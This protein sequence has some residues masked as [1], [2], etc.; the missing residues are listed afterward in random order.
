MRKIIK[1]VIVI[2]LLFTALTS[3]KNKKS[4]QAN[5]DALI[6]ISTDAD[7]NIIF[8]KNTENT[9]TSWDLG[10]LSI[11]LNISDD[12]D[13]LFE[14][15][16][17]FDSDNKDELIIAFGYDNDNDNDKDYVEDIYY[18]GKDEN[19]FIVYSHLESSCYNYY[20]V[21]LIYLE[22]KEQPVLYFR[23]TNYVNLVGFELYEIKDKA[24]NQM[25]YSASATGVGYDEMLDL[26]EDGVYTGYLQTRKSYDSLYTNL[27]RHYSYINGEFI[28]EDISADFY[29]YPST[30]EDVVREYLNMHCLLRLEN[31]DIP[32]IESRLKEL[33]PRNFNPPILYDYNEMVEYNMLYEGSIEFKTNTYEDSNIAKVIVNYSNNQ[34][35]MEV[36]YSL[37]ECESKWI[38]CDYKVLLGDNYELTKK[39]DKYFEEI[40]EEVDNDS[41]LEKYKNILLSQTSLAFKFVVAD[42][43]KSYYLNDIAFEGYWMKPF[44][45]S[46][47]DMNEDLK[48]ELIVEGSLGTVGFT[49]VIREFDNEIIAH[50]FSNRQMYDLKKDGTFGASG[51]A[52]YSGYF[53]LE[54]DDSTYNFNRIAET[55]TEEDEDGNVK[56]IFYIGETLT[57]EDEFWVFWESL[58]SKEEAEW[59]YFN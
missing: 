6:S 38:I 56:S 10:E 26:D 7:E 12:M 20:S 55:D 3:C 34:K 50:E 44:R 29:N 28:L 51:G 21:D 1:Y 52:A 41:I 2:I 45:F 37:S 9:G 16:Y 31:I 47:V 53:N 33:C 30:P 59:V 18:V 25:V 14:K 22:G 24:F 49:L 54:F 39:I 40:R 4:N 23:N 35:E 42:G 36:V 11:K 19:E 27:N 5:E 17:D 13:V 8:V 48:P 58:T 15:Y 32:D 46:L 43:I 57:D